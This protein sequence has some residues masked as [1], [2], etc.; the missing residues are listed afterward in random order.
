MASTFFGQVRSRIG[1]G[2]LVIGAIVLAAVIFVV[3]NAVRD[4]TPTAV[5]TATGSRFTCTVLSVYDGDGPINCAEVDGAGE[6]VS[7]R[8]RGIEA[9]EPDNTCQMEVCPPL[10]GQE[11]KAILT[12]LAVGQLQ[13]VSFGPS[14]NRVD[15]S[16]TSP[17]G[18]DISCE[19]IRTGAAVRWPEYDP[20]QRLV[21]C[22]PAARR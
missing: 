9:R 17:T 2:G 4:I 3:I 16:C 22:V 14:Y 6:Q 8:L 13:C 15:S 11:A 19:L 12:R 5:D 10:S 1:T 20:E 21:N 7:V 18:V